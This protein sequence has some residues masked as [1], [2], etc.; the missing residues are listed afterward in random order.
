MKMSQH[1]RISCMIIIM[2]MNLILG[3]KRFVV[4]RHVILAFTNTTVFTYLRSFI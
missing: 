2:M 3:S 1:F 4:A